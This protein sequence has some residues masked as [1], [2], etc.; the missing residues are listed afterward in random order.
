MSISNI[1]ESKVEKFYNEIIGEF[2]EHESI[3]GGLND[4]KDLIKSSEEREDEYVIPTKMPNICLYFQKELSEKLFYLGS[5]NLNFDSQEGKLRT[6]NELYIE[7]YLS[8]LFHPSE[9]ENNDINKDYKEVFIF[10]K[11]KG[12][13]YYSSKVIPYFIS[14]L[15]NRF[16]SKKILEVKEFNF[17]DFFKPIEGL[18]VINK[19]DISDE[20][21]E[22]LSKSLKFQIAKK[23]GLIPKEESLL[24]SKFTLSNENGEIRTDA[25]S[26]TTPAIDYYLKGLRITNIFYQFLNFYQVI[27]HY[28]VV[29]FLKYL[30][31]KI[32]KNEPYQVYNEIK[33][34]IRKEEKVISLAV[35]YLLQNIDSELKANLDEFNRDS[36]VQ[37]LIGELNEAS[38]GEAIKDFNNWESNYGENLGGLIYK[39]RNEVVHT[40]RRR[41]DMLGD[42]ASKYSNV[43]QYIVVVLKNI[44]EKAIEEDL[45]L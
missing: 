30:T 41:E 21:I 5:N 2:D 3:F 24:T 42:L 26:K 1:D 44:S 6:E 8:G 38:S 37:N 22:N 31:Q 14:T 25:K 34:N 18:I 20:G 40:K 23:Y 15:K 4:F 17:Y 9:N 36:S 11:G 16:I 45:G 33:K 13:I 28:C 27:E 32:D 39:I 7:L 35:S 19:N 10:I 43:F 12:E 29:Y